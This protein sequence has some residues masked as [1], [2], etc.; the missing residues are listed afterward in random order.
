MLR[1]RAVILAS[2]PLRCYP[3]GSPAGSRPIAASAGGASPGTATRISP[4]SAAAR[5]DGRR[6]DVAGGRSKDAGGGAAARPC[7]NSSIGASEVL[8]TSSTHATPRSLPPS[9][10]SRA[11]RWRWR[12]VSR[13][14]ECGVVVVGRAALVDVPDTHLD[15]K[16]RE[17]RSERHLPKSHIV[18]PHGAVA[19]SPTSPPAGSDV[20]GCHLAFVWVMDHTDRRPAD[21][22]GSQ[23]EQRVFSARRD[24]SQILA[25]SRSQGHSLQVPGGRR[26]RERAQ[27]AS[28]PTRPPGVLKDQHVAP[29]VLLAFLRSVR[30]ASQRAVGCVL[31]IARPAHAAI[32]R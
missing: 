2:P 18:Y 21:K 15:R 8:G 32:R 1:G 11:A 10:P 25:G 31:I 17:A 16:L 23:S 19:D 9:S 7:L 4:A 26:R 14:S 30:R 29:L 20:P 27:R 5:N 3:P 22:T 12:Q 6:N 24:Q 13:R 28:K